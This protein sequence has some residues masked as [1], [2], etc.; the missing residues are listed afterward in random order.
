M[1]IQLVELEVRGPM[2][3]Q[4]YI[5]FKNLVPEGYTK[6]IKCVGVLELY[7]SPGNNVWNFF[8]YI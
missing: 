3:F 1:S 5:K 7:F 6:T 4:K 2:L 8:A